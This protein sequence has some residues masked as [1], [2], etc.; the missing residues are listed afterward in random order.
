MARQNHELPRD[1]DIDALAFLM[2]SAV[3]SIGIR[4]RAGL[5]LQQIEASLLSISKMLCPA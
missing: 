4:A 2:T 1:I 5:N 3:H